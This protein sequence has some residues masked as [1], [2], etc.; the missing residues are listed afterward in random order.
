VKSKAAWAADVGGS[1]T[2]AE[3]LGYTSVKTLTGFTQ[4]AVFGDDAIVQLHA[5]ADGS[6]HAQSVPLIQLG[7]PRNIIWYQSQQLRPHRV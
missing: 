6:S 7:K 4:Y 3:T 5:G 1:K 2:D